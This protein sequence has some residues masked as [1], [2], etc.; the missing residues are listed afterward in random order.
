MSWTQ[1]Q[2]SVFDWFARGDHNL[3]IQARAGSAKTTTLIEGLRHAR[4]LGVGRILMC[5]FNKRIATELASR[6]PGGV[7]AKTVHSLGLQAVS[8]AWGG[9]E[10][11]QDRGQLLARAA[12]GPETRDAAVR[13][14]A[15]LASIA[16]LTLATT[17]DEINDLVLD[18][19]LEPS[20]P[21]VKEGWD[22]EAVIN[23][24]SAA[25][26]MALEP[27]D[28]IDFDDM[29]YVPAALGLKLPQYE[30][31]GL[32]EL[33]DVGYGQLVI[34]LNSIAPGGRIVG[35]GDKYQA[36]FEFMGAG[37]GSIDAVIKATGASELPLTTTFRCPRRVVAMASAYVTDYEAAPNAIDGEVS[38]IANIN[39]LVHR[40]NTGDYVLSRS[41]T[42]AVKACI[43]L[44]RSNKRAT[45]VGRDFGLG[46]S[47]LLDKAGSQDL[48]IALKAMHTWVEREAAKAIA[49]GKEGR[50]ER[51]YDRLEC[52]AALAEGLST[53]DE[54]RRRIDTLFND[55]GT[56]QI[57]CGTVHRMKGGEA[58]NVF[59][60]GDTFRPGKTDTNV[61]YVALT[62]AKK[63]LTMVGDCGAFSKAT[64]HLSAWNAK[65]RKEI[66][67]EHHEPEDPSSGGVRPRLEGG[68]L[69]EDP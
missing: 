18:Y 10:V 62:R 7:Q 36:I 40:A 35:A 58:D 64:Q 20:G 30:L 24:A 2:E 52:V 44:L 14:V 1:Q 69:G 8:R 47:K 3:V 60:L 48:K 23:A 32:D 61:R 43:A 46:V 49:I 11:Q 13:L 59:I 37:T 12:M 55:D 50:A 34:A 53:V 16:K 17:H 22:L 4:E 39:D 38:E 9:V 33:Q 27:G 15:R 26:R 29:I 67:H 31:V 65:Q 6:V 57:S 56:G 19:D 66:N 41:N 68:H 25:M 42:G 63:T 51:L 54:V 21:M 5:A 28:I 45:V